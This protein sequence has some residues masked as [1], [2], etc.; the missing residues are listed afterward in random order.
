MDTSS[1]FSLAAKNIQEHSICSLS[2][3]NPTLVGIVK[4]ALTWFTIATR[5]LE[6]GSR[7]RCGRSKVILGRGV[8]IFLIALAGALVGAGWSLTWNRNGPE[9]PSVPSDVTRPEVRAEAA[10]PSGKGEAKAP[11]RTLANNWSFSEESRN[12]PEKI[13]PNYTLSAEDQE[14]SDESKTSIA[15][16]IELAKKSGHLPRN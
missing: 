12:R 15:K 9:F 10:S 5:T 14:R 6:R 4:V 1:P 3:T 11:E 2:R 13:S 16:S 8:K 7:F